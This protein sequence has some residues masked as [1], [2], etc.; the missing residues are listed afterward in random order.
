MFIRVHAQQVLDAG[1]TER[2]ALR[3]SARPS[4]RPSCLA[5]ARLATLF[6]SAGAHVP[7]SKAASP[8]RAPDIP[9]DVTPGGG[10]GPF[11]RVCGG[12]CRR[13]SGLARQ[14]RA[15]GISEPIQRTQTRRTH[16][17]LHRSWSSQMGDAH[18][19]ISSSCCLAGR[20]ARELGVWLV[21]GGDA[22]RA[23]A[24]A[25]RRRS[26]CVP[27]VSTGCWQ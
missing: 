10:D 17:M 26:P 13:A 6:Q 16:A 23:Q 15:G 24:S 22:G 1:L 14:R 12:L 27:S 21:A 5:W 3:S 19:R 7:P 2:V 9:S 4:S 25:A 8:S 11:R 20:H 18:E